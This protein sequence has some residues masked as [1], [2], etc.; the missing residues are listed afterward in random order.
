MRCFALA[1]TKAFENYLIELVQDR[2]IIIR[3]YAAKSLIYLASKLGIELILEKISKFT[4]YCYYLF[5]DF[6][7]DSP[8]KVI[9]I[10]IK[11]ADNPKLFH[12]CLK[13]LGPLV[14]TRSMPFLKNSLLAE[15]V[16]DR[17][18]AIEL[19]SDNPSEDAEDVLIDLL[20]DED[21][22]VKKQ[23]IKGLSWISTNKGMLKIQEIFHSSNR[24]K[25]ILEAAR[26]LHVLGKLEEENQSEYTD[27]VLRFR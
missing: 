4:D 10:I 2:K 17:L 6:F 3:L 23:V 21:E 5:Q 16:E 14:V 8:S 26:A 9:D 12:A 7:Q 25:V 11:N 24:P 18:L 19:F 20:L 13:V 22:R 15:S 27:Y 1:P